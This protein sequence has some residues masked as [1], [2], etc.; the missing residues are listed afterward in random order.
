M[1]DA[2]FDPV[3][4]DYAAV[5]VRVA[6]LAA[7]EQKLQRV[8]HRH[9]LGAHRARPNLLAEHEKRNGE[10]RLDGGAVDGVLVDDSRLAAHGEQMSLAFVVGHVGVK[11]HDQNRQQD[12]QLVVRTGIIEVDGIDAVFREAGVCQDFPDLVL[13]LAGHA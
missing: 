2:E 13:G 12:V 8:D 7:E 10:S 11:T 3:V 5:T 6:P 9:L 4:H 1:A